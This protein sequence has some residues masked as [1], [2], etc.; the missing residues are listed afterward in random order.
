MLGRKR[1]RLAWPSGRDAVEAEAEAAAAAAAEEALAFPLPLAAAAA[2]APALPLPLPL[3]LLIT[4]CETNSA[5]SPRA[6]IASGK[7]PLSNS[8]SGSRGEKGG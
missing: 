5:E 4:L 6:E 8:S 2:A 1:G 3:L 7:D